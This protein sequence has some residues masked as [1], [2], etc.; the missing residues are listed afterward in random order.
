MR[1]SR[2]AIGARA[3]VTS[4]GITQMREVVSGSSNAGTTASLELEFGVATASNANVRIDWP[5]GRQTIMN[6]VAT[7]QF[8]TISE[9]SATAT[10]LSIR[11]VIGQTAFRNGRAIYQCRAEFGTPDYSY[12]W[13]FNPSTTGGQ[14]AN[15]NNNDAISGAFNKTLTISPVT[16]NHAGRYRCRVS[17]AA[18]NT[19]FSSNAL[20][21][22][23]ALNATLVH[24]DTFANTQTDQPLN[25]RTTETTTANW[26]A[27]GNTLLGKGDTVSSKSWKNPAAVLSFSPIQLGASHIVAE[28]MLDAS[29]GNWS[30]VGFTR[31]A[32]NFWGSSNGGQVWAYIRPDG[33]YRIL[34]NG[35][36]ID[37][38][39][40]F[41][42]ISQFNQADANHVQLSYNTVNRQIELWINGILEFGPTVLPNPNYV[43]NIQHTGW[44]A[45]N[46]RLDTT[47]MD[48]FEAYTVTASPTV[49]LLASYLP[50]KGAQR[51]TAISFTESHP[52]FDFFYDQNL[53]D[54]SERPNAS[55]DN[56]IENPSYLKFGL[57]G[58]VLPTNGGTG[59][60]DC[61][62]IAS[63]DST[64]KPF[65]CNT[66]IIEALNNGQLFIMNTDEY[67]LDAQRCDETHPLVSQV[68]YDTNHWI[69]V[70]FIVNGTEYPRRINV[71]KNS[72][73]RIINANADTYVR[74]N[75][76][77]NNFG[78]ASTL[79]IRASSSG[80]GRFNFIRFSV[81]TLGAPVS[82]AM[83]Q[84]NNLGNPVSH[85]NLHQVCSST[86]NE[87][88]LNWN[89]W[90][91][92]TNGSCGVL[93]SLS[94]LEQNRA[95]RFD[96]SSIISGFGSYTF[97]GE[98]NDSRTNRRFGSSNNSNFALRPVL[99][100][101][102]AH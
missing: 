66:D 3:Y 19:R 73:L 53:G 34:A 64:T 6:G 72:E 48:Q 79:D 55:C 76:P 43:P 87:F 40:G 86:W 20:L 100:I 27:N 80:D 77:N 58:S 28:A 16:D 31:N 25:G 36:A 8:L 33:L 85:L 21:S 74:Q 81:P 84:L 4:G 91:T 35:T 69:Q 15:I 99:K 46:A 90:F 12:R 89:N 22:V 38:S 39:N 88:T 2:D 14:W 50:Q 75:L 92:Q 59:I 1:S 78:S 7:N 96:V 32:L 61:T 97:G 10:E 67:Q 45:L 13:Q 44:S 23:R 51:T 101:T 60:D 68:R 56:G 42:S 17:D 29:A 5:S 24:A 30:A 82:S 41:R 52:L 18:S 57:G 37:V 63:W 83:V 62:F 47:R 95:Y 102:I 49:G 98:T 94:D 9:N 70:N 54:Y 11:P 65:Q 71:R 26:V 93:D